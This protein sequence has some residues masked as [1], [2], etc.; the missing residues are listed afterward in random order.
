MRNSK[1]KTEASKDGA[2]KPTSLIDI[3][4][5]N[6][7]RARNDAWIVS[8]TTENDASDDERDGGEYDANRWLVDIHNVE[9][10]EDCEANEEE[11]SETDEDGEKEDE[12]E[13]GD[14]D[15]EEEDGQQEEEVDKEHVDE[16]DE[17]EEDDEEEEVQDERGG[18]ARK[19]GWLW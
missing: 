6:L 16:E 8:C 5:E 7:R 4:A 18:G 17:E 13:D 3:L 11:G 12:E 19:S 10:D 15:G 2:T 9:D 14:Q 1:G